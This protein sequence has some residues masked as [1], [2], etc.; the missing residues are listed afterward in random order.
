MSETTPDIETTKI[1]MLKIPVATLQIITRALIW[2]FLLLFILNIPA[3][4]FSS[5][6]D[7][8]IILKLL[9]L[10]D[11]GYEKNIP[12]YFSS[13]NLLLSALLLFVIFHF[14]RKTSEKDSIYWCVL[15]VLFVLL[16][17]DEF[18]G[19]HEMAGGL[20]NRMMGPD[21]LFYFS[22]V[23]PG[24]II[25]LILVAFL[26]KFYVGLPARYRKLF[27]ISA[28]LFVSGTIGMEIVDGFLYPE[29]EV[30]DLTYKILTAIEETLEMTG[31]LVFIY[32]LVDYIKT[33]NRITT[34]DTQAIETEM[35][36][37]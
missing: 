10:V 17:I 1:L 34:Y 36:G 21:R 37:K 22:W 18:I 16:A 32:S 12:T 8:D 7:N 31:I 3:V 28:F 20:L 19:L 11:F 33:D 27:A 30:L 6:A 23:I 25:F 5:A 15:S 2:L 14:H 4:I 24:M 26:F 9:S 13:L 29:D 35:K